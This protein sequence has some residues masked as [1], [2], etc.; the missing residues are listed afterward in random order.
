MFAHVRSGRSRQFDIKTI[1]NSKCPGFLKLP[2]G[3]NQVRDLVAVERSIGDARGGAEGDPHW[4][5]RC[6]RPFGAASCGRPQ[7]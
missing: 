5:A 4:L 6:W 2:G 1:L 7:C 3:Q